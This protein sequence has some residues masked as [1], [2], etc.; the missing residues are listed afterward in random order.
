M[1]APLLE[2]VAAEY[3]GKI[4]IYKVDINVEQELS[5]VFGIQSIPSFLFIPM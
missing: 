2:E 1:V 4:I 3:D 5:T